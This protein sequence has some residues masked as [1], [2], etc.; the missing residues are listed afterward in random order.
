MDKVAFI[1]V[2]LGCFVSFGAVAALLYRKIQDDSYTYDMRHVWD[3][4]S[5]TLEGMEFKTNGRRP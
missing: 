5:V 2:M 1:F 4:Y 3:R